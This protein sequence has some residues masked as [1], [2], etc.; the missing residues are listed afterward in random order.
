MQMNA[1]LEEQRQQMEY[2]MH[3]EDNQTKILVAEINS[4]AEA[5]RFALMNHDNEMANDF[6]QQDINEK[7]RQFDAKMQQDA[8]KLELDKKK[9]QDDVR[10]REKQINKS[11]TKK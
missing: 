10:L 9:H 8:K 3:S 5:E 7:K 1:Q 4:K 2:Q 6:T 11:T